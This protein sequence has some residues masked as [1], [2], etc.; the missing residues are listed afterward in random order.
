LGGRKEIPTI[1]SLK[2][3][4]IRVMEMA[5]IK[6]RPLI[7]NLLWTKLKFLIQCGSVDFESVKGE[8]KAKVI[9]TFYWLAP[10]RKESINHWV[11]SMIKPIKN[12]AV[13]LINFYTT[14]KRTRMTEENGEYKVIEIPIDSLDNSD[15]VSPELIQN[16]ESL[17][18][19][20][21]VTQIIRRYG[22]TTKRITAFKL[23]S[24]VYDENFTAWLKDKK[25]VGAN[26]HLDNTDFQEQTSNEMFLRLV[27]KFVKLKWSYFKTLILRIK[28]RLSEGGNLTYGSHRMYHTA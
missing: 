20:I 5:E 26:S 23:M 25:Y 22:I 13:N 8:L 27:A 1:A 15:S 7:N 2:T 12:Y 17:E 9:Q 4:L 14:K 19:K 10:Y 16:T 18:N 11:M 21:T 3:T 24:G 6:L 28:E